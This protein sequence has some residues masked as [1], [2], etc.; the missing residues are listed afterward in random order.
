MKDVTFLDSCESAHESVEASQENDAGAAGGGAE[1][2]VAAA[3]AAA[4]ARRIGV[5][6]AV[7]GTGVEIIG[8]LAKPVAADENGRGR[9][10][11]G[12]P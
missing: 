3:A 6:T 5:G 10:V 2:E 12:E 9:S 1:A 8:S 11:T 4:A 7:D